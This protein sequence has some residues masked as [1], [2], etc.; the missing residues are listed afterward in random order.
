MAQERCS[1]FDDDSFGVFCHPVGWQFLTDGERNSLIQAFLATDASCI[2]NVHSYARWNGAPSNEIFASLRGSIASEYVDNDQIIFGVMIEP[3]I[4][5]TSISGNINDAF[6]LLATY[7]CVSGRHAFNTETG[8]RNTDPFFLGYVSRA[9][10]H[11]DS[12]YALREVPTDTN[13]V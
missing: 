13:G 5:L 10:D 11:F 12:S 6:G 1:A 9:A 2:V 4:S 7:L 8:D 3:M